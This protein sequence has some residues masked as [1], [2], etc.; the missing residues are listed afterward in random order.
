VI[1]VPLERGG[2]REVYGPEF[3]ATGHDHEIIRV[4]RANERERA[5]RL[6][7]VMGDLEHGCF[8]A[9]GLA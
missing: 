4:D 2:V 3:L 6:A 8:D 7:A 9:F 5:R 1:A